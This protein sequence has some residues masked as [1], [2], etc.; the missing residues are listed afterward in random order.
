LTVAQAENVLQRD[1]LE[2]GVQTPEVSDLPVDTIIGQQ[3][4]PGEQ[5]EQGQA[6]NVTISAGKEKSIVPP[7]VG[8]TSLADVE[9]ALADAKLQL[10]SVIEVDSAQPRGY[11]LRQNPAEGSSVDVGTSVNVEVSNGRSQVPSVVGETEGSARGILSSAGF[12]VAVIYQQSATVVSGTVL[13]QAPSAGTTAEK[14]TTV[15]LTVAIPVP[16]PTPTPTPT[17]T[18]EPTP[19]PTPTPEPTPDP[20]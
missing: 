5:L 14:G 20:T 18:P 13:A 16:E 19:T 12:E 9:T 2:L 3:P 11:V 17:P 10:G 6:V 4:T 15:T 7:L 8:L 1:G